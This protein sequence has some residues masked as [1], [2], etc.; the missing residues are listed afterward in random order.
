[1]WMHS[2]AR[3]SEGTAETCAA[4]ILTNARAIR[5]KMMQGVLSRTRAPQMKMMVTKLDVDPSTAWCCVA[6]GRASRSTNWVGYMPRSTLTAAF[7]IQGGWASTVRLISTSAR[8]TLAR[9]VPRAWSPMV[10]AYSV[11]IVL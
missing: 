10:L 4:S 7:V 6:M 11:A 3:V 8:A 2:F 5:A 1:M 9:I